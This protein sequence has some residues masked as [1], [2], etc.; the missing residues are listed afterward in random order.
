[1]ICK[2]CSKEIPDGS[3]KC[4]FC[5]HVLTGNESGISACPVEDTPES[6]EAEW[7][8]EG[9]RIQVIGYVLFAIDLIA[10][11]MFLISYPGAISLTVAICIGLFGLCSLFITIG[12]GVMV[13]NSNKQ[14][15]IMQKLLKRFEQD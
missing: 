12:F 8:S 10:A 14:T 4:P 5:H 1:M 2:N 6:L 13:S 11:I 9:V 3:V 15:A 7:G